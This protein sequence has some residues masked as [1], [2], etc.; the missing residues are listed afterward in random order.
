M[1]SKISYH[2]NFIAIAA[3]ISG[4]LFGY[5]AGIISGAILFIKKT[6]DVT[7]T[8]IG[9]M[10][11]AVPLGALIASIIIGRMSDLFGRKKLLIFTAIFFSVGSLSCVFANTPAALIAG[12]LIMGFAV[13]MSSS[14]S[15]MYISEMAEKERRGKLVTLYLISVNFGILVSYVINLLLSSTESWR[16]MLGL[17]VVP[18]VILLM[19]SV[20][21]PESARWLIGNGKS[22]KGRNILEKMHGL[23]KASLEIMEIESV[24]KK[25]KT[26]LVSIFKFKFLKVILI[27]VLIGIFTQAVGINA[28]IYYAPT[29]FQ[30]TGF[31]ATTASMLATLGIGFTV[32][33]SAVIASRII[34]RV[35][36]RPLLL[37]GLAGIIASL[38]LVTASFSY[39]H[40]Q[41]ILG[42]A[43]LIGF[44]LFVACQGLSVGPACFLL[45]SEIFPEN[46][47]GFGMGISIM[48]NWLTNFLVAL[49][50]PIMLESCG[51][52]FVFKLFLVLSIIGFIIFYFYI[53][54]TRKVSLEKIEINIL[55]NKKL[56]LLGE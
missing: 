43:V 17:S 24:L 4:L 48:F 53:P 49:L 33:M 3:A 15:P 8:Q 21:L 40:N 46:I 36:R 2:I 31:N 16:M 56:R 37:C 54:E 39:I 22:E 19:F 10:V 55:K 44:I 23:E 7:N 9:E 29:I 38:F 51:T 6:F 25:E 14:L 41:H 34:D 18:A 1:V 13:G 45:P 52:V 42:W 26:S 47:R 32:T 50:F 12:R 11:S 35:G 28:I 20:F 5:D 30:K 27:G